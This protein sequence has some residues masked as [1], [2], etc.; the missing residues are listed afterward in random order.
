M[1]HRA[2]PASG[3][4]HPACLDQ[5]TRPPNPG[6]TLQKP[7]PTGSGGALGAP[8]PTPIPPTPDR[9]ERVMTRVQPAPKSPAAGSG[10]CGPALRRRRPDSCPD[11]HEGP[12]D[13]RCPSPTPRTDAQ[14]Q[15]LCGQALQTRLAM[16]V[17]GVAKAL[18]QALPASSDTPYG[19]TT[20]RTRTAPDDR[21]SRPIPHRV[22]NGFP[23][24]G[25]FLPEI[26]RSR[27]Q[28][29][30]HSRTLPCASCRPK[31]F[32]ATEPTSIVRFWWTP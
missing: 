14:P 29:C 15:L 24:N 30:T 1:P 4:S 8:D 28:S 12:T 23:I 20:I 18:G 26:W 25:A 19:S 27:Y 7:S 11:T 9:A 2:T 32:G 17:G 13:P 5:T 10:G 21:P 16:D 3:Q 6:R 22:G 31:A